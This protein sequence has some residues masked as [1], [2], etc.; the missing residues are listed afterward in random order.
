[1]IFGDYG[2]K[3]I[4][5]IRLPKPC[6]KPRPAEQSFAAKLSSIARSCVSQ[7]SERAKQPIAL[8]VRLA[9]LRNLQ[10]RR[11]DGTF[12]DLDF[13]KD[14]RSCEAV[15]IWRMAPDVKEA[16]RFRRNTNG[17]QQACQNVQGV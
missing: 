7:V 5:K 3:V 15:K 10:D 13:A 11:D 8:L 17:R 14:R 6:L 4:N 9:R 12:H 2:H 16:K 1:M